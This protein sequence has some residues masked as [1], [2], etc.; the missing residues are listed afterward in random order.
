TCTSMA[1][2]WLC[3]NHLICD[4]AAPTGTPPL[5][6]TPFTCGPTPS[7]NN[8]PEPTAP[9]GVAP[10]FASTATMVKLTGV[11]ELLACT[12]PGT[13]N[14][15]VRVSPVSEAVPA[16]SC[17]PAILSAAEAMPGEVVPVFGVS[18]TTAV[19]VTFCDGRLQ[20]VGVLTDVIRGPTST[21]FVP[22]QV[23]AGS[24][25]FLHEYEH[26]PSLHVAPSSAPPSGRVQSAG[27]LQEP[28][29]GLPPYTQAMEDESARMAMRRF[30]RLSLGES[31]SKREH[32]AG[33]GEHEAGDD[34]HVG[35][36]GRA[37]GGV[38]V[39]D[40]G[41][42]VHAVPAVVRLR[43]TDQAVAVLP[44]EDPDAQRQGGRSHQ[45]VADGLSPLPFLLVHAGIGPRT[46]LVGG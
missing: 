38:Q 2:D 28:S 15:Y 8:C 39:R 25:T 11:S 13:V 31:E 18:S 5:T 20:V 16:M 29:D 4:P 46:V 24:Q 7:I 9:S 21:Q 14:V 33:G 23:S 35:D 43:V 26:R 41:T 34:Q 37:L 10:P 27:T 12:E 44:F 3:A 42:Q 30:I 32:S 6:V 40:V 17:L 36:G 45:R 1:A 19:T 22:S